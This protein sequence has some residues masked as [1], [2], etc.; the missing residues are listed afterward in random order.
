[1]FCT[2]GRLPEHRAFAVVQWRG[3]ERSLAEWQR[4]GTHLPHTCH[5]Q[6]PGSTVAGSYTPGAK[7]QR[8]TSKDLPKSALSQPLCQFLAQYCP[9]FILNAEIN[10][11]KSSDTFSELF[12]HY[13]EIFP[14]THI[15]FK[16][17]FPF[18]RS[19]WIIDPGATTFSPKA[20]YSISRYI[21]WDLQSTLMI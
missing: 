21:H 3:T 20:A 16:I 17:P 6:V 7:S 18:L 11:K 12:H 19:W 14:S 2:E 9:A 1:M 8:M 5:L 15:V 10:R 4:A 13:Y